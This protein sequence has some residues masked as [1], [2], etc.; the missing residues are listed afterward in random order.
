MVIADNCALV[1]NDVFGNYS[2]YSASTLV[3]GAFYLLSRYMVIFRGI[4]ILLSGQLN[5][6]V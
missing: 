4:R 1:V 2:N 5:Y 6:L 3:L